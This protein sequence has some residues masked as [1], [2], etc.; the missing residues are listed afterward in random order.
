MLSSLLELPAEALAELVTDALLEAK[1]S[2][3]KPNPARVP[4]GR[5]GLGLT[6]WFSQYS[7]RASS[8]ATLAK[9]ILSTW[10]LLLTLIQMVG[11]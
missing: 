5:F 11:H 7:N 3:R 4:V 8:I 6:R 2:E 9:W 10:S 1:L